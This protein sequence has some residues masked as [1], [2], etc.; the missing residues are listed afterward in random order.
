MW[1]MLQQDEPDDYVVATGQTHSVQ[2]F[3][4]LAFRAAGIDDWRRYVR[5]DDRFLRPS[6]VDLL[7]GDA[8]KARETLGWKPTVAFAELV[9]RMVAFDLENEGFKAR[10]RR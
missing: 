4:E 5:Q 3:V 9:E 7:V 8:T 10:N 2:E 6:E 1:L